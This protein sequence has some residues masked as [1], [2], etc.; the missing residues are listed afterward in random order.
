MGYVFENGRLRTRSLE[1]SAAYH[2][3]LRCASCSHASPYAPKGFPHVE[4]FRADLA[5][6]GAALRTDVL[7][8]LGG[9]PLLN[10]EVA[11]LLR[12]ARE[13]RIAARVMVTTNGLL[14]HEMADAFWENVDL[15][16]VTAYPETEARLALDRIGAKAR[17]FGV[18][19]FVERVPEFRGMI[20]TAPQPRDWV[21]DLVYRSCRD[22]HEHHCHMLHEG[23]LY[24]CPLPPFLPS[25][26][27][28][29]GVD[30]YDPVADGLDLHGPGD[31]LQRLREFLLSG[32]TPYSCAWCLGDLARREPHR[33]LD[34]ALVREPAT[35]PITRESH[36]DRMRLFHA[37]STFGA[38]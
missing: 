27:C 26:L 4:S 12:T 15:V 2:C 28:K 29:I 17:A 13:S 8:I 38:R 20:L 5:A 16:L 25:Y 21:T 30:A 3:N 34:P 31:L 37:V 35:I 36:L 14:L 7:R 24:R 10:P 19:L 9:E 1:Y 18:E 22:V 11:A 6:L 33:Q 23:R 32:T